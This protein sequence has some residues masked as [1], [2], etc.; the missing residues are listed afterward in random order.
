MAENDNYIEDYISSQ[1]VYDDLSSRYD[2]PSARYEYESPTPPKKHAGD[3]VEAPRG[4]ISAKTVF[5][6][7]T[8]T[9]IATAV[10]NPSLLIVTLP[11]STLLASML[12]LARRRKAREPRRIGYGG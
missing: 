8:F 11:L 5:Y 4:L 9:A 7:V 2:I 3:D 6:I 1:G 12:A 10:I